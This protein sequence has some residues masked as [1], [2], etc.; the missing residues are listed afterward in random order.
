MSQLIEELSATTNMNHLGI[1][2]LLSDKATFS[3][4]IEE[5][6]RELISTMWEGGFLTFEKNIPLPGVDGVFM[7]VSVGVVES[8]FACVDIP[9][10]D[11]LEH[12]EMPTSF[13]FSELISTICDEEIVPTTDV[14]VTRKSTSQLSPPPPYDS[15]D[16][17]NEDREME[18]LDELMSG[19]NRE[20]RE[21]DQIDVSNDH[22]II[23]N[24]Y[25]KTI[26]IYIILHTERSR[27]FGYTICITRILFIFLFRRR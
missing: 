19:Y 10:I 11:I 12:D 25:I 14:V 4:K 24:V 3:M 5:K 16:D 26:I 20:S 21:S 8:E 1:V 23:C 22:I 17:Q 2:T 18:V 15:F 6:A 27:S 7:R 13:D 9:D